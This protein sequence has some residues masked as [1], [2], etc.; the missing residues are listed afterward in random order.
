MCC[1]VCT[2]L[3]ATPWQPSLL[4]EQQFSGTIL[5]PGTQVQHAC[6]SCKQDGT[7]G[8]INSHSATRVSMLHPGHQCQTRRAKTVCRKEACSRGI[9]TCSSGRTTHAMGMWKPCV[10]V[11]LI[12]TRLLALEIE[13]L[14]SP[15]APR[16]ALVP[17]SVATSANPP[18]PPCER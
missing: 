2:T 18:Q 10:R 16:D 4:S 7:Y 14:P 11:P 8:D 15:W 3:A 17:N 9:V 13:A 5:V 12:Q 6:M 1:T